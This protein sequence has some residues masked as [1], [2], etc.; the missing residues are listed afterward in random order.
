MG[1]V[2]VELDCNQKFKTKSDRG[3]SLTTKE[4]TQV[5]TCANIT[6]VRRWPTL[7]IQIE[8][9]IQDHSSLKLKG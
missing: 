5:H 8:S 2:K 7:S 9:G 1:G 3:R 4:L 6:H